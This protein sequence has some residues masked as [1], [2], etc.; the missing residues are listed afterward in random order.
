MLNLGVFFGGCSVEHEVSVVS[1]L[2]AVANVDS[3]KYK[4]VGVYLS[5]DAKM[6]TGDAVLDVKNFKDIPAL[7]K[8]CTQ[9]TVASIK[10]GVYLVP[11]SPSAFGKKLLD[12]I[13]VAFPIVHGTNCEDGSLMGLFELLRLPYVGC[14]VLSSAVGMDKITQKKVLMAEKIPVLGFV[15]VLDA[16]YRDQEVGIIEKIEN[17]IGYPVIVKPANLGSSVGIKKAKDRAALKDA[18]DFG[19]EFSPKVLVERAVMSLREINCSVLGDVYETRASVCEEPVS[20][21][22]ILSY[23]DKYL[24]S[25]STKGMS[26]ATRKIPADISAEDT[27]KI[28]MLAQAAFKAVGCSGVARID[29]LMDTQDGAIYL[30]EI[31]TIP[32]SLSFYLWKE[33]GVEYPELINRLVDIALKRDRMRSRLTY[34][35]DQNILALGDFKG[36]KGSKGAKR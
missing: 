33:S 18:L 5:K 6:Y 26:G 11:V 8:N 31:N 17:K 27:E 20:A 15:S 1:A 2:Q 22:E 36:F 34:T 32:G 16:Q 28:Q 13:D 10:D 21:D 24:S 9:V 4:V 19:F 12:R 29:F 23:S 25:T 35:Y 7:L 3:S 14:D 30:N